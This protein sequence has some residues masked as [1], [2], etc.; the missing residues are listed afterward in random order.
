[1]TR[2]LSTLLPFLLTIIFMVTGVRLVM[3]NAFLYFEYTRNGFPAD[4]YG[5]T[6]EDRLTYGPIGIQY[7]INREPLSF[8]QDARL[9]AEKCVFTSANA[10]TCPMFKQSEL[11]HMADVQAVTNIT[12]TTSVILIALCAIIIG[13]LW[14]ARRP[15]LKQALF[16]AGILTYAIV[17]FVVMFAV[18]AWDFF[19]DSFHNMFF[20]PG[21]WRFLYSDTLIRLYPEQFWFDAAVAVGLIMILLATLSIVMSRRISS[22]IQENAR[23]RGTDERTHYR[24]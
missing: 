20:E 5:F 1:M 24:G 9:P 12:F 17:L 11:Q 6:S 19:F 21:T 16:T 4:T 23:A 14:H 2:I 15:A 10:V 7:L 22:K 3:S 8:L 13:W 18:L